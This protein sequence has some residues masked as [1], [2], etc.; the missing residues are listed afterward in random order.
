M[1]RLVLFDID[2]TLLVGSTVHYTALKNALSVVYGIKN[3]IP[4]KNMQGMT[5]IK[6]IC[7]VLTRKY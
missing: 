2:K 4:V 7:E 5:S 6:I 1:D 3:P